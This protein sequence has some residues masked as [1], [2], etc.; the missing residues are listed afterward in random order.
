[1]KNVRNLFRLK[2]EIDDTIVKDIRNLF[3]L[4][5][6]NEAVKNQI[7]TDISYL[8]DYE[9]EDYYKSVSVGNF[10]SN[11]YIE[12]KS[13]G[14]RNKALPKISLKIF[15]KLHNTQKTS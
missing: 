6:E 4:K 1:M 11:D 5:K 8:F 12:Y 3:G 15:Q 7:I 2:K 10:W 14:D 13:N 9:E